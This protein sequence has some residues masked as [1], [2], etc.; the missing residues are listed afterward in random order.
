MKPNPSLSP[1]LSRLVFVLGLAA[2]ALSG[3]R[4]QQVAAPAA[5]S[6]QTTAT[7]AAAPKL[8]AAPMAMAEENV[9]Q[10]SPFEVNSTRDRGYEAA[11][12]LSGTRLNTNLA[13]LAASISVVTRQQLQDTA[14]TDINDVFS[15]EVSTEGT[16]QW[17][18]FTI[19]RGTVSDD[20]QANP[21]GANRM[22]GL[23]SA[24]VAVNGFTSSLPFDTYNVDAIEISRGPNSSVFGLGNTGGGVNLI[25][26]QANVN[27]AITT[28][29]YR[30]DSYGGYR[31]NFDINRPLVNG[32]FAIRVLG[33]YNNQGYVLK[34][35]SDTTRRLM[36]ALTLRPLKNSTFHASFESY[37]EFF[38]RPNSTTP[39]DGISDWIANGRPTYDPIAQVVHFGNGAPSIGAGVSLLSLKTLAN[40][41]A[42]LPYSIQPTDTALTLFPSWY[43]QNGQIQLYEINAMP[44]STGTG[45]LSVDATTA[46]PGLHLL[47][48][49]TF[50]NRYTA[51]YPL[52]MTAGLTDKSLYDW[53][54][55]NLGAPNYGK[56]K[57][58][59]SAIDFAQT[60]L[61]TPRQ[62]LALQ[63]GWMHEKL[64]G[65][66]RSFL[67][68][69]GNAGGKFQ[70]SIDINEK[71]LD[72]SPNPYF[73]TPYLGYPRPGYNKSR[74]SVDDYRATLAYELNLTKEKGWLKY[75][76]R[77]NLTAYAEYRTSLT[78]SLSYT[79]TMSSDE[80]WI[81]ATG[82]SSNRNS[83]GY[84]PYVHYIVGD[85]NGYN[86]DYGAKGIV[87]P[88]FSTTLRYY[89]GVTKQ[90]INEPVDFA[91]Y[92]FGN[93]PNRKLLSTVGGVWQGY[94]LGDRII[95][96]IGRRH[97]FFRNQ[98]ANSA[99]SPTTATDGFYDLS[100]QSLYT[101]YEWVKSWGI[102]TTQGVVVKPLS[103]MNLL[104]NKSNSFTPGA[105]AYDVNGLP[106]P[107]PK[108]RTRDY[109]FQFILFN[110]RLSIRA[111]QYETLDRGRADSTVNTYVQRTLRMDGGTGVNDPNLTNWLTTQLQTKN[112]TWT[113]DQV[114]AAVIQQSGVD[115][116]YINGHY[117]KTHGD[118]GSASSRG[119]EIEIEYNPS[120]YWTIK[121]TI[122]Q[123]KPFNSQ[124]SGTL[125]D[126]IAA[127]MPTWLTIKNPITPAIPDPN[128]PLNLWWLTTIGTSTPYTFYTANVQAPL[129]LIIATQ[130][131]QRPQT[132]EWRYN[133]LTNYKLAGITDNRWLKNL[134][135]GGAFRWEDKA[136]IGYYGAAPDPDGVVRNYDA[137]R[138]IWDTTRYYI[139]L[140][141]G[142]N[143]RLYSGKVRCRLQVNVKNIFEGGRLQAVA[144]NP[145]GTPYA[146]RIV[147]PR[148]FLFS[149]TFD[150]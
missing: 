59:T 1:L 11:S 72:G 58:E 119:K 56:L 96:T 51:S 35:S 116:T 63:L 2:F 102:T 54:S 88:P 107:D 50:Y 79:D 144:M 3:L 117:S 22:R 74:S 92:Y 66:N 109:G 139:D 147:D 71:L 77:H 67:G 85:S 12:T 87:A 10:L 31:G 61:S 34:P 70:V 60:I 106:L 132:R 13:D 114:L 68:T 21:N 142:Y 84:R 36:V 118:R 4:A 82:V 110:G 78:A 8:P 90:W 25:P 37:R 76:G 125:Q 6:T 134:D 16:R 19:D 43:V 104:Y 141:A 62:N 112:P 5:A 39:R 57:G 127:R 130:G 18:S 42:N 64:A 91:E 44:T 148:Q 24:N 14:S 69:Y 136:N 47:Y 49:T 80:A 33:L 89:N 75:F 41:T 93:R 65:N 38:N 48:N 94:F 40:E 149:A 131:K 140:S 97:D 52:Y 105:L 120:Q 113:S 55:I 103:W 135:V 53:T 29:A 124:L 28:F 7:Q 133:I 73:L 45:P 122:T 86:V 128:N 20:I 17:T 15:Y 26:S 101:A 100:S 138:P 27:R 108:G 150:L 95:P 145:D 146:F 123:A 46:A 81:S 115:P 99:I 32:K 143:L 111:E 129:A 83:S 23:G 137:N 30:G 126:Y 98:D 121:T 9:V